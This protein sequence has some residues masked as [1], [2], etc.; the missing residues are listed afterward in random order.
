MF[1]F[2]VSSLASPLL[3][4]LALPAI[5]TT[6][7]FFSLLSSTKSLLSKF[8]CPRFRTFCYLP[9][10]HLHYR[11]FFFYH[12]LILS[13]LQSSVT[14]KSA[15]RL[16]LNWTILYKIDHFSNSHKYKNCWPFACSAHDG[17]LNTLEAGYTIYLNS[18]SY[19]EVKT[20]QDDTIR[21]QTYWQHNFENISVQIIRLEK[22][23]GTYSTTQ[24]PLLFFRS[25]PLSL[26][27]L[28]LSNLSSESL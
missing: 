23:K 28:S 11:V 19:H 10:V 18:F 8:V 6:Y 9:C 25:L 13:Q 1:G 2:C 24:R 14:L 7:F 27:S 22:K 4:T 20:L 15:F 16:R 3:I 26:S 5:L 12:P 17:G 21:W